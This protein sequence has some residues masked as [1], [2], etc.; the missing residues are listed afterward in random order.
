MDTEQLRK[1]GALFLLKL[2]EHVTQVTIDDVVDGYKNL[3][4][5]TVECFK[6]RVRGKL[7]EKGHVSTIRDDAFEDII[8]PF[9]GIETNY[10]QEKY[11]RVTWHCSK[12]SLSDLFLLMSLIYGN[13]LT[14]NSELH[15]MAHS[16]RDPNADWLKHSRL[17]SIFHYLIL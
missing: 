1:A 11:F 14:L 9:N 6:A 5:T 3:F 13:E 16:S 2:K 17:S 10:L 15:T 12:F 8:F 4:C 7:A